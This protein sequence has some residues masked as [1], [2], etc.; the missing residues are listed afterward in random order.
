MTMLSYYREG[1]VAK[2]YKVA[3]LFSYHLKKENESRIINKKMRYLILFSKR[4]SS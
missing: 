2:W 3:I 1:R 4:I